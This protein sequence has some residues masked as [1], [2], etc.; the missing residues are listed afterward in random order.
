MVRDAD[1][2]DIMS[3]MINHFRS[4]SPDPIVTL[5]L[6]PRAS[7]EYSDE[8]YQAVLNKRDGDY[9]LLQH[10]NDFL[11]MLLGWIYSFQYAATLKLTVMRS[12]L[13]DIFSLLP[14]DEKIQKLKGQILAFAHYNN[15]ATS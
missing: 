9:T 15:E 13:T 10:A 12:Y 4:E 5:G 1:K 14:N 3:L 11:L 8:V 6:D 2:L 7:D